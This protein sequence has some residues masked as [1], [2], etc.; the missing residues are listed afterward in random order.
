MEHNYRSLLKTMLFRL[1]RWSRNQTSI[2][3]PDSGICFYFSSFSAHKQH[4]ISIHYSKYSVKNLIM[5]KNVTLIRIVT[6]VRFRIVN[7]KTTPALQILTQ[8]ETVSHSTSTLY[9][10]KLTLAKINS[11]SVKIITLK[12]SIPSS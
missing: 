11:K 7:G 5:V 9:S 3:C 2:V 4:F 1:R 8:K 12:K 10:K 6:I